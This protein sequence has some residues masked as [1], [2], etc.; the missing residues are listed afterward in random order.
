MVYELRGCLYCLGAVLLIV[1]MLRGGPALAASERGMSTQTQGR[2]QSKRV[3][4][5]IG[6]GAYPNNPL[7]NT[8]NDA[9]L[10]ARTLRQL[11]FQ[12]IKGENLTMPQMRRIID[13]F[14]LR[15]GD[16][17]YD[18]DGQVDVIELFQYVERRVIDLT[19]GRQHPHFR[20]GGGSLPIKALK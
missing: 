16:A 8:V 18:H 3:A 10:L 19:D 9:R 11:G 6:N 1:A 17:D 2:A 15:L 13:Q 12:V 7:P 5:V 4:L 14:G 20:M